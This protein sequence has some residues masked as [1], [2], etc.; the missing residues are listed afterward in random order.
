VV[1]LEGWVEVDAGRAAGASGVAEL[2]L[3]LV[4]FESG[5]AYALP[6]WV[7]GVV[8]V[9]AVVLGAARACAGAAAVEA[10]A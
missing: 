9:A 7:V 6:V 10:W 8:E 3:A 1:A 2:T 4:E 5:F